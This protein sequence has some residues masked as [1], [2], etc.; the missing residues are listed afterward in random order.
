MPEHSRH[1]RNSPA[2]WIQ[3]VASWRLAI[4]FVKFQTT[5][6]VPLRYAV[7]WAFHLKGIGNIQYFFKVLKI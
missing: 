2:G 5:I 6:E 4:Y 3:E 1:A 7:V